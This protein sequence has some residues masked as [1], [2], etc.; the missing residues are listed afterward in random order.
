L[1]SAV[2]ALD[3]GDQPVA[4]AIGALLFAVVARAIDVG[5][6]PETALRS[7]ALDYRDRVRSAEDAPDK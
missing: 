4:D 7:V 3:V 2:E 6:D 5:V 1:A